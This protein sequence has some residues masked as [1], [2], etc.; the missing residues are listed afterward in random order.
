MMKK[1]F[2][3]LLIFICFFTVGC[4]KEKK[5]TK[6]SI[7]ATNFPCYDFARAVTKDVEDIS[8]EILLKPGSESHDFEPTPQ[9]I[10]DIKN[11][12]M[13]IYVGGESDTWIDD[14]LKDIDVNKTKIIKLTDIVDL[15]EEETVEGMEEEH[16]HE[17][18][19]HDHEEEEEEEYDEHVWTSPVNAIKIVNK[20][21]EE[22]IN[23]D[24]SNKEVYN[25]N[26]SKYIDEL[27]NIDEKIKDV[28]KNAKRK[29]LVFGDRFPLRYFVEEYKLDY[30]A[31]FP[32]CSEQ[33]EASAKTVTYLIDYVK[34]NNIPV[35]FHIELSNGKIA[36]TIA[37]E[38]NAKVLEFHTA[39][40]ISKKDFDNEVTFVDLLKKD[41]EVLKEALN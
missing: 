1:L 39:H 7:V 22:V 29:V 38:T 36:D 12:D 20:I 9:D 23:I 27:S 19:D 2:T 15:Y 14:I 41:I 26:A 34:K 8:V 6:Y 25:K 24:S 30:R 33:T 10:I 5:S 35:V 17:E 32:G 4:G 40:N 18:H 3:V 21:K 11:S 37:E 31:A 28:V 16:E 13:F